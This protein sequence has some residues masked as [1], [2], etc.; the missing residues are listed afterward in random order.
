MPVCEHTTRAVYA[1]AKSLFGLC[2]RRP[3]LSLAC[4][5]AAAISIQS[6]A[7]QSLAD[8]RSP[9]NPVEEYLDAI[10]EIEADYGPYAEELSDMY[11][12]LGQTL[13][14]AGEYLKARDAFHR[15]VTVQRVNQ[16]PNNPE[17][18]DHLYVLANIESALGE[19][20]A[21]DRAMNNIYHINANYYGEDS[22]QMLPVLKRIYQ[23]YHLMRPLGSD[24]AE[25]EDFLRNVELTEEILRISETVNGPNHPDTAT[26]YRRFGEAS[27]LMVMNLSSTAMTPIPNPNMSVSKN[28]M[29]TPDMESVSVG[30]YYSDGRRAFRNYQAALASNPSTSPAEMAEAMANIGDW[31][32]LVEKYGKS[33]DHYEEGYRVLA[34]NSGFTEQAETFMNQPQPMDF[35]FGVSAVKLQETLAELG[36]PRIEVSMTVTTMG[37]LRSIEFLNAPEELTKSDLNRI[38]RGLER[39]PFRPALKD[40]EVVTTRSFIWQYEMTPEESTS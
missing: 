35:I 18:A 2:R 7:A 32:Q 17:Q 16:G 26:A 31:Y 22:P 34:Q 23:W 15:A 14:D 21:A 40:G 10:D 11:L 28:T 37:N 4:L 20:S 1:L 25:F 24:V 8:Y 19:F 3:G 6:A 13:I 38:K 29:L 9:V 12:G 33:I 39:I 27:F 30:D 36:H 5:L